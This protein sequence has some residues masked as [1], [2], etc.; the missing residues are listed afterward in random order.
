MVFAAGWGPV[1]KPIVKLANE[2]IDDGEEIESEVRDDVEEDYS[3]GRYLAAVARCEQRRTMRPALRLACVLA[4]CAA[5]QPALARAWIKTLPKPEFGTAMEG[6]DRHGTPLL[7][8]GA[9]D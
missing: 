6:C 9:G 5:K 1:A 4:A 3:E 8:T 2:C 7:Q